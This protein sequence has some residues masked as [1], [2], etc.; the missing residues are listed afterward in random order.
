MLAKIAG[1]K[2]K[3]AFKESDI[4]VRKNIKNQTNC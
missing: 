1:L 2:T 3:V 4:F